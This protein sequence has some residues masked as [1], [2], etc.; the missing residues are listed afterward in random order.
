MKVVPIELTANLPRLR[1]LG[2]SRIQIVRQ[3]CADG[4]D[5]LDTSVRI[6]SS[7]L[8]SPKQKVFIA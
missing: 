3:V 4:L 2:L 7:Q 8:W 5:V 6:S 1:F